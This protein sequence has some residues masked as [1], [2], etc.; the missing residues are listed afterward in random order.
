MATF[1]I[2]DDW[3]RLWVLAAVGVVFALL[4]LVLFRHRDLE[5]AGDAVAFPVLVPVFQV[6]CAI[7]VA[8]AAQM[9]L[10]TFTGM[11]EHQT[12]K[13]LNENVK[14]VLEKYK[15]YIGVKAEINV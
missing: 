1:T 3:W 8:A 6:L 2:T 10:C 15:E 5:C 14:P 7:F 9:F 13:F 12:E 11:S 4:G